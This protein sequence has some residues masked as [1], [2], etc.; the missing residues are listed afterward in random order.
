MEVSVAGVVQGSGYTVSNVGN[1]NGGNVTFT[2]APRISGAAAVVV[3]LRRLVPLTQSTNLPTQ[4]ALDTDELEAEV[5]RDVMRIQQ[6]NEVDSRTFKLPVDSTITDPGPTDL[7]GNGGKFLAVNA[8]E[9][10]VVWG[11]P[12]ASGTVISTFM[13]TVVDDTT[14]AAALQTL[15]ALFADT[16]AK[17]AAFSVATTERG[18][19]FLCSAASAD[20]AATLPSAASAGDGFVVGFKKTDATIYMITV[21]PAGSDTIDGLPNLKLR[22]LNSQCVLVSDGSNWH[23][24]SHENVA[25]EFSAAQNG[26]FLVDQYSHITRTSLGASNVHVQDRWRVEVGGS[27]SARWTYS[28]ESNGGVDGKS[29]FGKWLC[30]T[31]DASPG[32]TE[33][34]WIRQT[35]I[36]N[37]MVGAGFL[38]S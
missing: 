12:A 8:G 11:T 16:T 4:G 17:T 30:T 31:A 10:A 21:T 14:A 29:K 15:T 22:F 1:D 32:S 2:T 5:D 7:V 27:A 33:K 34:Q 38:G 28:V 35:V 24:A 19:L 13:E 3:A 37:T 26:G 36:S 18:I 25:I 9:T 6:L 20:Y 23:L